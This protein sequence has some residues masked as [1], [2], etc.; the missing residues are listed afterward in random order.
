MIQWKKQPDK[1]KVT[2]PKFGDT[3]I[4]RTFLWFPFLHTDGEFYWL[5]WVEMEYKFSLIQIPLPI[6]PFEDYGWVK[7]RIISM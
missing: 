6:M 1:P 4:K 7:S 3:K 5:G 2:E